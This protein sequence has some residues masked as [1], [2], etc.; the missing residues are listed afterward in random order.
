MN[1]A[2][3]QPVQTNDA[4]LPVIELHDVP[5]PKAIDTLARLGDFN[6]MLDP[7]LFPGFDADGKEAKERTV[8]FRLENVSANDVLVRLLSLHRLVLQEDSSSRIAIITRAGS[9]LTHILPI[10]HSATNE[11]LVP[12]VEFHDV[13]LSMAIE[14]LARQAGIN[15]LIDPALPPTARSDGSL[16][17]DPTVGFYLKNVKA[18]DVLIRMLC[19][20][21]FILME[22]P[23]SNIAIITRANQ[24]TNRLFMGM[25]DM[26]ISFKYSQTNELIPLIQFSDVPITTAIE[27][28]A[29]QEDVSYML[30]HKLWSHWSGPS[31]G[32]IREPLLNIRLENVTAWNTLNRLLNLY[33]VVMVNNPVTHIWQVRGVD[34]PA[35]H[36]DAGLL[37]PDTNNA[38]THTNSPIPLIEF[39]NVSLQKALT[40]LIR[41]DALPIVL[42]PQFLNERS[43]ISQISL[44]LRWENTT[45]KQALLALCQN[46]D[47]DIVKDATTGALRIE[48]GPAW[49]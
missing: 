40:A 17:P 8:S 11:G 13:P 34:E 14:N 28:L 32:G 3:S 23:V 44:S 12:L 19:V 41:Q 1:L 5:L 9:S 18:S 4:L 43:D 47:L 27:N 6:Y 38:D 7:A 22:D 39:S 45:A 10:I 33:G 36:L 31:S 37:G 15:Y 35:Y 21:G 30:G 16:A 29:R 48:P 49:K 20:Y 26:A 46:Y 24:N 25:T 42:D 2:R